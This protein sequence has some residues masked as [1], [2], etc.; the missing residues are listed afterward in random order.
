MK[1]ISLIHVMDLVKSNPNLKDI[2]YEQVMLHSLMFLS[3]VGVPDYYEDKLIKGK[4][5]NYRIRLQCDYEDDLMVMING[6]VA[7]PSS[8]IS[9]THLRELEEKEKGSSNYDSPYWKG[10]FKPI[11]NETGSMYTY[12]V[13]GNML[14]SN[15]ESGDIVIQYSSVKVDDN[16]EI[17]VPSNRLFIDALVKFIKFRSYELLFESG[18]LDHRIFA[19]VEQEYMWAVGKLESSTKMLDYGQAASLINN[20]KTVINRP[21]SYEDRFA[22]M[23]SKVTDKHN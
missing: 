6:K 17:M 11:D 19:H 20:L 1:F 9:H 8:D 22:S 5:K 16:G 4:L 21:F 15:I 18:K 2:E 12:K 23:P 14:Y 13:K 10:I 7:Y 3:L